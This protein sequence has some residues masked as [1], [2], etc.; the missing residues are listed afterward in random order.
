MM[1]RRLSTV[2]AATLVSLGW[3]IWAP[4][5]LAHD[6]QPLAPHDVWRA[7]NFDGLIWLSLGA[8]AWAYFRGLGVL[9]HR[10]G[11]QHQVL[12]WRAVSFAAGL[13]TLFVALVS[14]LHAL[15]AS[16]FSAHMVQHILLILVA[17][18]LLTLGAPQSPFLLAVP[19]A[20]RHQLGRIWREAVWLR[21]A[22][23]VFTQPLAAW[24]LHTLTIWVWHLPDLYQGTLESEWIHV[25]EHALF[26]GT[27][28]LFWSAILRPGYGA[29]VLSLF[30][31]TVN[32]TLLSALMTFAPWP[33]YAHYVATAPLWHLTPLEDQQLAGVIMWIPAGLGYTLAALI[34][35]TAWLAKVDQP[36]A[37][38]HK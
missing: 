19:W 33:W 32:T 23:R 1:T 31:L 5:A 14:P 25:L 9:W 13:G 27:G 36:R 29:G 12:G 18:P 2:L 38:P 24:G 20:Q 11:V 22:R 28:L 26:L 37:V 16:L 21:A 4:L 35:F 10:P 3:L 7:W 17:A 34:L 30:T 6:G 8:G 15:G